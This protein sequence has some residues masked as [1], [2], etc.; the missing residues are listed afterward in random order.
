MKPNKLFTRAEKIKFLEGLHARNRSVTE[1]Q[2]QAVTFLTFR[3]SKPGEVRNQSTNQYITP[4]AAQNIM[5]N[6]SNK[7]L[8]WLEGLNDGGVD[9]WWKKTPFNNLGIF[10]GQH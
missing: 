5:D 7:D 4:Q 2:E 1:L 3:T 6:A 10:K 9:I 8:V